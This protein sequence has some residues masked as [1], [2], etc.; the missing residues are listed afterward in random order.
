MN[1]TYK[2]IYIISYVGEYQ[3][4]HARRIASISAIEE[5]DKALAETMAQTIIKKLDSGRGDYID[6]LSYLSGTDDQLM[7]YAYDNS[8]YLF[9]LLDGPYGI[10]ADDGHYDYF[11]DLVDQFRQL[12]EQLKL[13]KLYNKTVMELSKHREYKDDA[14]IV[15]E[16]I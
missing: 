14:E 9:E 8:K 3:L 6:N 13:P 4:K 10:G 15:F 12:C 16:T 11:P 5:F 7:E 2:T 1:E